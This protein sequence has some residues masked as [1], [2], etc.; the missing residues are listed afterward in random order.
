MNLE[1]KNITVSYG[2]TVVLNDATHTFEEGKITA[3]LGPNGC[4]KTTL[5][6]SLVRKFA[7]TGRLAYIPQEI[8]GD[9]GLTV[10]E[11]VA[12]GRYD[13][14]RFFTGETDEDRK[15]I[16]GALELMELSD[17]QDRIYDTLSG[18]EKQRAMAARAISQD[19]EWFI[20]DE[21]SSN[22]DI[23]HTKHILDTAVRLV[24][25]QGKSFIIVLHD[26]NDAVRYGDEFVLMK[27]GRIIK[28]SGTLSAEL[29]EETYGTSF[30]EVKTSSGQTI[31]YAS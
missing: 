12:L 1:A 9:V 17:K 6:K 13:K 15:H 22:L 21:P 2:S 19:A 20:M 3:V 16:D 24:K 23:V 28:V 31:F 7:G 18:G 14:S 29:L 4:G 11:T 8:Y 26:I 10:R 30:G 5:I 25:E 27:E